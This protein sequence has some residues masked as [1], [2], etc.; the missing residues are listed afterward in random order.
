MMRFVGD[1][2]VPPA[3]CA[4]ISFIGGSS[5]PVG[6]FWN[7]KDVYTSFT[8]FKKMA[9]IAGY[10]P[11]RAGA[12]VGELAVRDARIAELEALLA[13]EREKTAAVEVLRAAGF[14][15]ARKPGRPAKAKEAV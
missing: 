15:P 13:A 10:V 7:G 12:D 6:F 8:A 3:R 9:E 2:V 11:A 5:D 14:Q 1:A 4:Y